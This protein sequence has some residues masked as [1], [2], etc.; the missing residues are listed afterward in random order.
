[1][2]KCVGFRWIIVRDL[3]GCSRAI[4][5]ILRVFL[6]EI[7]IA[8][9]IF[10]RANRARRHRSPRQGGQAPHDQNPP[11]WEKWL[12]LAKHSS[13]EKNEVTNCLGIGRWQMD[14]AIKRHRR[15]VSRARTALLYPS[16]T[17]KF[18]T[19]QKICK[20]NWKPKPHALKFACWTFS[21]TSCVN[22]QINWKAN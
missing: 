17:I 19:D 5:H 1:M 20:Q 4:I 11:R 2:Q 9:V 7:E 10:V 15:G 13:K 12:S 3:R 16:V 6:E 14:L 18:R 22:N 21:V 8:I